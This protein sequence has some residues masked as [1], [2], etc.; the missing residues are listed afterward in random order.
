M[1]AKWELEK[2]VDCLISRLSGFKPIKSCNCN[3]VYICHAHI[4]SKGFYPQI[5]ELLQQNA[6]SAV[7]VRGSQTTA[8]ESCLCQWVFFQKSSSYKTSS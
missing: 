6:V 3:M 8:K 2:V 5:P 4:I 7:T 1:E